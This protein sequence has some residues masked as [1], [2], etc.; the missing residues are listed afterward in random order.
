M[1]TTRTTGTAA[2]TAGTAGVVETANRALRELVRL[3]GDRPWTSAELTEL[4]ELRRQWL[5]AVRSQLVRAA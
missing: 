5:T 4:A 2:E 1:E 3:H